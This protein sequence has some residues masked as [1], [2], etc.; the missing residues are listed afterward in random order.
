MNCHCFQDRTYNPDK[1]YSTDEYLLA[2]TFNSFLSSNFNVPKRDIVMMKMKGGTGAE[3]VIIALYVSSRTGKDLEEL[4]AKRKKEKTWQDIL[5]QINGQDTAIVDPLLNAIHR[6]ETDGKVAAA[7][8]DHLLRT[9]FNQDQSTIDTLRRQDLSEKEITLFF[10]LASRIG[11]SAEQ[12]ANLR[13]SNSLSLSEMAHN[14]GLEPGNMKKIMAESA[15]G[16]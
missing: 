4:T 14:F 7:I 5:L 16:R 2:T 6:G 13:R 15:A 12:L 3:D 10:L 1:K 8:T 9:F 11:S